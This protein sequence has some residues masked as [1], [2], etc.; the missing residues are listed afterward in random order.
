[1]AAAQGGLRVV[2]AIRSLSQVIGIPRL[3]SHPNSFWS[4]QCISF[5]GHGMSEQ[6]LSVGLIKTH[7]LENGYETA[8]ATWMLDNKGVIQAAYLDLFYIEVIA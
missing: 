8:S 6:K 1:M 5:L 4:S 2:Q 7:D 3:P